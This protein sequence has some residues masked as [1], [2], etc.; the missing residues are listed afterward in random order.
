MSEKTSS[1]GNPRRTEAS[2]PRA[3]ARLQFHKDF[4][5][6]HA[7]ALV[8][9]FAN[10]GVSHL[11]ASPILKARPG[12]THGYDCVDVSLVN[13]ELGGEDAL[14]RMADAAHAAGLG[15][16]VDI[17]PNH[18]GIGND[19]GWWQDVLLWGPDSRRAKYFDIDWQSSDPALRGK[20]LVPFL[21]AGYG[22]TLASGDLVLAFDD[23]RGLRGALLRQPVPDRDPRLC[24]AARR[25]RPRLAARGRAAV[26]GCRADGR[27]RAR[28]HPRA[29]RGAR[30]P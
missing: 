24:A 7:T 5:F 12:S 4:T 14:R 10:L 29:G 11:Y 16:V 1:R 23:A 17:V 30:R 15:L 18:M 19:N 8:P 6:E 25:Q 13:P 20:L 26:R 2:V 22:E 21:G 28:R 3:T 9:Y 27:N